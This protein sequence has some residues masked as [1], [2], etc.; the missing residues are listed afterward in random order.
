MILDVFIHASDLAALKAG[1]P[2]S[3]WKQHREPDGTRV[4]AKDWF[5]Q[6]ERKIQI[7]PGHAEGSR[8]KLV[9]QD[10]VYDR[11]GNPVTPEQTI[12]GITLRLSSMADGSDIRSWDDLPNWAKNLGDLI[13]IMCRRDWWHEGR[14]DWLIYRS[15]TL[16]LNTLRK[17]RVDPSIAG[18]SYPFRDL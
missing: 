3:W 13:K 7:T 5:D 9:T 4:P 10:A 14:D 18:G 2:V 11:D 1:V 6:G 15:S 16:P 8:V 12:A 17:I